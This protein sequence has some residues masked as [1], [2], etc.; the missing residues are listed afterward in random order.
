[1]AICGLGWLWHPVVTS[2]TVSM[3]N[4]LEEGRH[5]ECVSTHDD[6]LLVNRD[7]LTRRGVGGIDH[8]DYIA[9]YYDFGFSR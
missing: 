2:I 4:T 1:L 7:F 3:R 9:K 5:F 6:N 8:W